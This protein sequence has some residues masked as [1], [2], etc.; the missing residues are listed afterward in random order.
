VAAVAADWNRVEYDVR[1]AKNKT[2]N[3]PTTDA[4]ER[5]RFAGQRLPCPARTDASVSFQR[6]GRNADEHAE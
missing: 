3:K 4:G 2:L 5:F 6:A 1:G